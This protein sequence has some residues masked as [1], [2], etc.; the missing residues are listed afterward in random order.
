MRTVYVNGEYLPESDA[1]VSV[2]DRGF[3]FADAVYE[4]VPILHGKLID[5]EGHIE[6]LKRSMSE[7]EMQPPATRDDILAM[8]RE[9]VRQNNVDQGM[10]YLQISRGV[11]D[12]DFMIKDLGCSIVAFTQAKELLNSKKAEKGVKVISLEDQRWK[13]RDIKTVQLL[14][15]S[16]AKTKAAKAGVDDAWLVENGYVTEGTSNN[17]FIVDIEGNIRTRSLSTAILHGIT[18]AA[19]LECA[20]E[21]DLNVIEDK[22][23]IDDAL[24][25]SEAFIS[26]ASLFVTPVVEIDG[27]SI[28]DGMPGPVVRRLREIYIQKSIDAAI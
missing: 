1:V 5:F 20:R 2:F 27:Q 3:L 24:R 11:S 22:F 17:A 4:V 19:I 8:F 15:P 28:G 6:R 7:L 10:V 14:Y 26:A 23:T 12:R 18:R 21:M 13:R 9:L 25:A 16:M